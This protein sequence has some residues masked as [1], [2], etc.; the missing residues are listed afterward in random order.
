MSFESEHAAFVRRNHVFNIDI[1]VFSAMLLQNFEGLLN[2][3]SQILI[4]PLGVVNF[5]ADIH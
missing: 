2:Q 1:C 4:F 3:V 5:I